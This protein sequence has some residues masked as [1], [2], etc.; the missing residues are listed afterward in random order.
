MYSIYYVALFFIF[1]LGNNRMV[2]ARNM[3]LA[4]G[5]MEVANERLEVDI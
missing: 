3:Y 5:L 1:S 4:F 2:A